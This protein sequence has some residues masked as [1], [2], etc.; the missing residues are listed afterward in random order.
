MLH[1]LFVFGESRISAIKSTA[2]DSFATIIAGAHRTELAPLNYYLLTNCESKSLH[3][4]RWVYG[5]PRRLDRAPGL[6]LLSYWKTREG[7]ALLAAMGE[8]LRE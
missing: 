6:L 8:L 1:S 4:A 5:V 7:E 3:S 2:T